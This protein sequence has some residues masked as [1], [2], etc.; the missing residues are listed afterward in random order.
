MDAA[1]DDLEDVPERR[2]ERRRKFTLAERIEI[3]ER[4][5]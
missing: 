5:N 1:D 2:R 4:D 3:G